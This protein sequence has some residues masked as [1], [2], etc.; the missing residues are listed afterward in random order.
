[1]AGE[2]LLQGGPPI[3]G[4]GQRRH[5]AGGQI[6]AADGVVAGVGDIDEA[7]VAHQPLRRPKGAVAGTEVGEARLAAPV[8]G[9]LLA[10][11]IED[12]DLVMTGVGD[13]PP[14]RLAGPDQR[15]DL[16][17]KAQRAIA[18]FGSDEGQRRGRCKSGAPP[19]A[20]H[21]ANAG[22]Q[23]LRRRLALQLAEDAALGIDEDER[24][25]SG[26]IVGLPQ[27]HFGVV[28]DG[29]ADVV[30]GDRVG[31]RFRVPFRRILWR[32]DA[33]DDEVFRVSLLQQFEGR[34]CLQAVDAA[35]RP[36]VENDQ[37][38]PQLRE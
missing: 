10:A 7:G 26:H 18:D 31:D 23:P 30:A 28:D 38:P 2:R 9:D 29:M 37:T 3:A 24:R 1:M 33:D 32:V 22:N 20:D 36:E 11:V 21:L 35:R 27:A 15:L 19:A 13:R 16:P 34:Q 4:A 12:D 17:R 5:V 8:A 25:P 14:L 6:D